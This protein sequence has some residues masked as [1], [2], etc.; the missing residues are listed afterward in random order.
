MVRSRSSAGGSIAGA[1][2]QVDLGLLYLLQ[3]PTQS[4]LTIEE[5]DDLGLIQADVSVAVYIQAKH[6]E[7]ASTLTAK[8]V[9]WWKTLRI[10]MELTGEGDGLFPKFELV[11]TL[12]TGSTLQILCRNEASRSDSELRGLVAALDEIADKSP[13]AELVEAYLAWKMRTPEYKLAL[14]K[15]TTIRAEA[16]KLAEITTSLREELRRIGVPQQNLKEA[17]EILSEWYRDT[18]RERLGSGGCRLSKDEFLQALQSVHSRTS[19]VTLIFRHGATEI[20]QMIAEHECRKTYYRQLDLLGA[21]SKDFLFAYEMLSRARIERDDWLSHSPVARQDLE[22]HESDLINSWGSVRLRELRRE[23]T[24][25][26]EERECGWRVHDE[27]VHN[28]KSMIRGELVRH[29]VHVGTLH[30]L[31]DGPA[32]P[33][34]GWHPRFEELLKTD[35]ED[36]SLDSPSNE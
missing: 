5:H 36:L 4:T 28:A 8:S 12:K 10:W 34:V 25:E 21:A 26:R 20:P 23:P 16:P 17:Q 3:A 24:S 33:R 14:L 2:W 18:V 19:A 15:S 9:S 1:L 27:C 7:R 29:H 31:A 11:T 32:D 30:L 35:G 13:N 22:E 6:S